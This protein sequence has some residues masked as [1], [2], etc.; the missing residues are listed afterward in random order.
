MD[1]HRPATPCGRSRVVFDSTRVVF[2]ILQTVPFRTS[3][4][5]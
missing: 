1:Y 2:R 4:G 5:S 3:Q